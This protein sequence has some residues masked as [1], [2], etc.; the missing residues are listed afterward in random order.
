[1]KQANFARCAIIKRVLLLRISKHLVYYID[2]EYCKFSPWF[3]KFKEIP[4]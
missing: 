1:M 3:K 4:C 2:Q